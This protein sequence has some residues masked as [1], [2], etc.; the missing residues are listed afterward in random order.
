[1]FILIIVETVF[2]FVIIV[3]QTVLSRVCSDYCGNCFYRY[4]DHIFDN[5]VLRQKFEGS[6]EDSRKKY[7]VVLA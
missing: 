3:E 7:T 4:S 1:M 2:F 6:F 5:K